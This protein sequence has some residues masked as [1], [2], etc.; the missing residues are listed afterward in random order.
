MKKKHKW[1]KGYERRHQDEQR[2][3]SVKQY[4]RR[5][6]PRLVEDSTQD[7]LAEAYQEAEIVTI[8]RKADKYREAWEAEKKVSQA[9]LAGWRTAQRELDEVKS[10]KL[11][12][13]LIGTFMGLIAGLII[14]ALSL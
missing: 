12:T 5:E 6:G 7:S 4:K 2:K 14:G 3:E 8:Q 1:G 9:H 10:G 13:L 11:A